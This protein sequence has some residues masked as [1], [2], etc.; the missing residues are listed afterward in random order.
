[1]E[2]VQKSLEHVAKRAPGLHS[3]STSAKAAAASPTVHDS[4]DQLIAR[5]EAAKTSVAASSASSSSSQPH[6]AVV[7]AELKSAVESTQKAVLDRQREFHA[8][9]SKSAK[10]LDK[11]FPIPIDGVADPSLFSSV[12]A[13]TALERVILNHLQRNGDWSTSYKFAAEAQLPWSEVTE[14]MYVQLHNVVAAMGRGDLRPAI[15]W[16]ERESAWLQARKSPLEFALHRSEFIRIATGVL[17]TGEGAD[18]ADEASNGDPDGE[19]VD[20]MSASIDQLAPPSSS[21]PSTALATT[22]AATRLMDAPVAQT[23][24]ERALAYGR[25]HFKSFRHTH[26]A[27]I[28][29]LFTLLA[30]LPAFIPAPAYGP[31]GLDSVPVEHL[32]PT[33]PL[34]Y[35]PLLDSNLVH[36]PLLEPLF[37]LEFCARN[38]IPRDAPLAI[39]VEVGAGGALNKIIKVK[40]VMKERGNEW[41]QADELPVSIASKLTSTS[42]ADDAVLTR[43]VDPVNR[44]KSHFQ[45]GCASI[46]SLPARCPRS[47][48]RKR[49][50]Q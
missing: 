9:L 26:L 33:V 50:H 8:A 6:P 40:A 48:A 38:R 35:R 21:V 23:N 24:V 46:R 45:P 16:A 43:L 12:E 49:I 7:I 47:K 17:R 5:I 42:H 20:M 32:V 22:T 39:G 10:A 34:I 37:R 19:N 36:A 41:S 25:E 13:Q 1:M 29:R 2:A 18:G 15:S 44:S 14:A 3:N 27:E 4:I 30:F 28:Q 31:E 11:K